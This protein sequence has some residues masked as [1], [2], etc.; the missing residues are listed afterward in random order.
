MIENESER[1]YQIGSW[2]ITIC[3]KKW[4]KLFLL[5]PKMLSQQS[6]YFVFVYC[7]RNFNKKATPL[8]IILVQSNRF[9]NGQN[10]LAIF[11][12]VSKFFQHNTWVKKLSDKNWVMKNFAGWVE[13]DMVG[14]NQVTLLCGKDPS[15]GA[16]AF[17][18]FKVYMWLAT[19]LRQVVCFMP[20]TLAK[21]K[22]GNSQAHFI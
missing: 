22:L 14:L 12:I 6:Q 4:T 5:I 10:W 18:L 17:T 7:S 15:D 3:I 8:R 19:L 9:L 16:H 2:L 21:L 13:V 11:L 20:S 1:A